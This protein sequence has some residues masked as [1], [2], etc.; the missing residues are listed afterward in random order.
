MRKKEKKRINKKKTTYLKLLCKD[1][2]DIFSD[3]SP[4]ILSGESSH[5]LRNAQLYHWVKR[6][7]SCS[8]A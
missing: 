2:L 4:F 3:L 8:Y 7:Q 5:G 6:I 1:G